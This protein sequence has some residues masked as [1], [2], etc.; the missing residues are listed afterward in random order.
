MA[1]TAKIEGNG[2]GI[3][4]IHTGTMSGKELTEKTREHYQSFDTADLRYQIMDFRA[5]DRLEMKSD[6]IRQTAEAFCEAAK[7]RRPDHKFAIVISNDPMF[8]V[9]K[10]W[11]SY[12]DDP[13]INGKIFYNMEEARAWITKEEDCAD[14]GQRA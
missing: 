9:M 13:K 6:E 11:S 8:A 1:V 14:S 2:E 5:V 12:L 10:L 3:I 4:Y 7:K